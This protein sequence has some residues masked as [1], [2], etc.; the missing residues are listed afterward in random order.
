MYQRSRSSWTSHIDFIL[1]DIA[2][3][4]IA[5]LIAYHI[6]FP[7]DGLPY[8]KFIYRNLIIV[9]MFLQLLFS[10]A[11]NNLSGVLRRGIV[12]EML[13]VGLLTFAVAATLTMYLFCVQ[14]S[15]AFS[16]LVVGY[17][18]L[19]YCILDFICRSIWKKVVMRRLRENGIRSF[20]KVKARTFFV[21]TETESSAKKVIE[22]IEKEFFFPVEIKGFALTEG[23]EAREISGIPV[24]NGLKDA[25]EFICHEWIDEVILDLAEKSGAVDEFLSC[26][27]EMGVTVHV[28]MEQYKVNRSKQFIQSLGGYTVATVAYNY[29]DTYQTV[30]KRMMDIAGGIVGSLI[31]IVIGLTIG[32]IIYINS[33]GP[34]IFKQKRIGRN[35]K[36]FWVY[37]FRSMYIDAEDRKKSLMTEN[38][39]ADGMMFKMDFDP[40]VIGNRILPDGTKK[41]GIGEFIRKTSLDEFPQ[42]FNVLRGDMSLVG[43]RPPTLDEWAKY[44]YHHRARMAIKPGITGMWQV[45]GRSEITDFEEVVKLDTEYI[46]NY[47]LLL[48]IKILFKTV[49]VLLQRKG[50]L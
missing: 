33:P 34:I 2:C 38:R 36:P 21:I 29:I 3:L 17:T 47:R 46:L 49:V 40:R 15:E 4:Q 35:G 26:C 7:V 27:A 23:T 43:T 19:I 28:V 11:M 31:A 45:S 25:P 18:F 20:S 6:R 41:T 10:M 42:F 39:V 22:T 48:D 12:Q 16:R 50:A 24:I 14:T 13:S 32:P 1:L 9:I 8:A 44:K 37:K 30:I 5:Y